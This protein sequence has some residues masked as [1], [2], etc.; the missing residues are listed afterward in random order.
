MP[1]CRKCN[2]HFPVKKIIDG[3]QRNLQNRKFCLDCSPF[4]EHNTN[5]AIPGVK[6]RLSVESKQTK[7]N[8]KSN[9]AKRIK[10]EL[11]D[12]H[13]GECI[14]CGYKKCI[15]A[16]QFHHRNPAEKE[17]ELD[18]RSIC[19]RAETV[20]LAEASKCDLLCANCHIEV[21]DAQCSF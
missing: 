18:I 20:I 8:S 11:V 7:K 17:F 15:K 3:R 19:S 10:S 9:R 16:L 13:G 2:N 4:K 12:L 21:H 1:N 6:T 5:P 14:R